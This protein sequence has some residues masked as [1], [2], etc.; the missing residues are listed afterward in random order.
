MNYEGIDN[1][2]RAVFPY[3]KRPSRPILNGKRF[4]KT[5]KRPEHGTTILAFLYKDGIMV[6]ADRQETRGETVGSLNSE[7]IYALDER[8][9]LLA[10]GLSSDIQFV[11]EDL[12]SAN[13]Y[14]MRQYGY[15]LSFDGKMNYLSEIL[16]EGILF[17]GFIMAAKDLDEEEFRICEVYLD[18]Y[19]DEASYKVLG[20][21]GEE[22]ERVL[23]DCRD[24]INNRG[25][26]FKDSVGL[27]L[28]ALNLA[29]RKDIHTSALE[30]AYPR[31]ATVTCEGFEP[32]A[33]ET[34][35]RFTDKLIR[36]ERRKD[37]H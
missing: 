5:I 28:R 25:L 22:A 27:A 20:S 21:G 7:K 15:Y 8:T 35:K 24:K 6:A 36:N 3:N 10:S 31:L 18:G 32:I 34:I 2:L 1:I 17:A 19:R 11:L 13:L 4:S 9:A 37:G 29:G 16:R 23:Y 26:S 33:E 30:V 14:W 12:G